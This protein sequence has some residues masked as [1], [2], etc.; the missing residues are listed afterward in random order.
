MAGATAPGAVQQQDQALDIDRGHRAGTMGDL[1]DRSVRPHVLEGHRRVKAD[2]WES[3]V[4]VDVPQVAVPQRCRV[5][6]DGARFELCDHVPVVPTES[7]NEGDDVGRADQDV[8]VRAKP[9]A[10]SRGCIAF[11]GGT[12]S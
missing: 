8:G 10:A 12:D 7:L 5:L 6:K 3:A 11:C 2:A 1:D 9:R 4:D